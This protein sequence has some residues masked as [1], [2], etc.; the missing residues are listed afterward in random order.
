[1]R[2]KHF[3]GSSVVCLMGPTASGKTELAINL[4]KEF[5][6]DIISVDSAQVY[7]GMDIGTAKPS[8][9]ILKQYPHH[10]IDICDP[11]QSYSAGDFVKDVT[12]QINDTQDRN[13]I[14]LL[15]GGTMLY[16]H[17]LVNGMADL[18]KADLEVRKLIESK[19]EIIGWSEMHQKLR[20]IDPEAADK[21]NVNDKQRIQRA[22]EVFELSG[23]KISELHN[24]KVTNKVFSFIKFSTNILD[25][26]ELHNRIN[27][28]FLKMLD[29]GFIKEIKALRKRKN[30]TKKHTSMRA[31]GYRQ[32]WSYLDGECSYEKAIEKAQASTRQLAKRQ[33]TWLKGME[34]VIAIDAGNESI[35][36]AINS[37]S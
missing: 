27:K 33:I 22:L 24:E 2:S 25:R 19:A 30:L 9:E 15:V 32:I 16:F 37:I 18:P 7:R 6:I 4:S 10:L 20:A 36:S 23:R 21:I 14:P 3:A 28:R 34:D 31:V 13:R 8:K 12:Q 17:S 5:P 26:E 35:V 11:E 29:N 1:M